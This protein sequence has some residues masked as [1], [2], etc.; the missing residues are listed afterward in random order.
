[1]RDG[2]AALPPELDVSRETLERLRCFEALLRKWTPKINLVAKSTLDH[3]WSRHI[4][5]S[6]QVFRAGPAA[7]TWADLGTGGGMPGAV[8]ALVAH[9]EAPDMRVTLIESDQRKCA[10]LRTVARETGVAFR[11]LSERIEVADPQTAHR[12]S[13]RALADLKTLLG[14]A[15]RHLHKDG[16]AL[17]Q[18]GANWQ[19]ELQDARRQWRFECERITSLTEDKAVI[20]KIKG[21]ERA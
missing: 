11:V 5:D 13:A 4:A 7:P 18:K 2:F 3:V 16:V 10:F 14:F 12:V 8:V 17:F 21:I 1:M 9:A 19:N 15:D 6:I 20:L